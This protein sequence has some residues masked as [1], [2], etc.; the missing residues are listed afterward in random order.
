MSNDYEWTEMR[1]YKRFFNPLSVVEHFAKSGPPQIVYSMITPGTGIT[2]QAPQVALTT[3][4]RTTYPAHWGRN[5]WPHPSGAGIQA[6][7]YLAAANVDAWCTAVRD[8]YSALM[9]AEYFPVVP[10]TQVN[11]V[12]TRGLLTVTQLQMDNLFDVIRR[13]RP[14]KSTYKKVLAA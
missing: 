4:E 1:F 3:T 12:T 14:S 2:Y 8:C 9:A 13:R 7:G 6:G 11:G 5:Y 10:I